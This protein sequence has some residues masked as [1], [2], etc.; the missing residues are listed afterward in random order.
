MKLNIYKNKIKLI[1][2]L[3]MLVMFPLL[4]VEAALV[5]DSYIIYENVLHNF[6]GPLITGVSSSVSGTTATITW[7]TNI[8]ADSYVI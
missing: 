6:D 8:P 7:I 1:T 4:S 5:S 2:T 3:I